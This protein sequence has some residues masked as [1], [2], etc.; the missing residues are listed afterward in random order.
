[1]K[2]IICAVFLVGLMVGLVSAQDKVENKVVAKVGRVDVTQQ[3]LDRV[4]E[5]LIPAGSMFHGGLSQ[6]KI[7]NLRTKALEQLIEQAHKVQ[8][9]LDEEISI[10]PADYQKKLAG[11]EKTFY[12][13]KR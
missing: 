11:A 4:T 7:E 12:S 9:A 13:Q 3:E 5:K 10:D 1:M 6:D 2:K 8:Y